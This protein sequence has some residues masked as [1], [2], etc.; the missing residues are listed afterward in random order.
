MATVDISRKGG[1]IVEVKSTGRADHRSYGNDAVCGAISAY[2]ISTVNTFTG[3]LKFDC[4]KSKFHFESGD[5]SSEI[6]YDLLNETEI[7]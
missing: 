7:I 3:I 1:K 4:D 6:N 5:A 2:L